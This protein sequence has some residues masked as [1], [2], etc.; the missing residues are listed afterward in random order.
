MRGFGH[1]IYEQGEQNS[2]CGEIATLHASWGFPG[3]PLK[4]P[5]P[6]GSKGSKSSKGI[7]KIGTYPCFIYISIKDYTRFV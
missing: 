6:K 4:Y 3:I 7:L 5:C 1:G 2:V